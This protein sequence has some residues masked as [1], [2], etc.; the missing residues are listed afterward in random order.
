MEINE[1][2]NIIQTSL[3]APKGQH[4]EFGNYSYRSC[5]DILAAVKPMLKEH[6]VAILLT[7]E[8]IAVGGQIFVEATAS[9]GN[10]DQQISVKASA[11]HAIT[12]K[13]MDSAQIT[14]SCSS[15]ARKYALSGL[16]AIDSNKDVDSMDNRVEQK[17][18]V[19]QT[20]NMMRYKAAEAK[21]LQNMEQ[22]T[23]NNYVKI[24]KEENP[25]E[26][27]TELRLSKIEKWSGI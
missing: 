21:A 14:G 1:V 19:K 20:N 3:A 17:A 24:I 12:K 4:N 16:L 27:N 22:E 15:Y 7:D 8:I 13:G 10:G 6:K 25:G 5:E 11:M 18:P 9:I 23:F 2:L 26:E